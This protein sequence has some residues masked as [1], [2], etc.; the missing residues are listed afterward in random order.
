MKV[1]TDINLNQNE[2]KN[3]SPLSLMG[4]GTGSDSLGQEIGVVTYNNNGNSL[5]I[6]DTWNEGFLYSEGGGNTPTWK[7]VPIY[8]TGSGL[9]TVT[10]TSVDDIV[11]NPNTATWHYKRWSDNSVDM[12][13]KWRGNIEPYYTN[14]GEAGVLKYIYTIGIPLPFR[15]NSTLDYAK[16]FCAQTGTG[17]ATLAS[18]GL[19]DFTSEVAVHWYSSVDGTDDYISSD[20]QVH[21]SGQL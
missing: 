14:S 1:L 9:S 18:G 21:V 3:N 16:T 4:G 13:L 12:W 20:V 15:F 19:N 11:P 8:T 5:E 17:S 10:L 7:D 6:L 2:I